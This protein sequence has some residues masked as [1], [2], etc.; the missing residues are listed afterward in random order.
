MAAKLT[1]C[2]TKG[3]YLHGLIMWDFIVEDY[4]EKGEV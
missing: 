3:L 2:A 4:V 1:G